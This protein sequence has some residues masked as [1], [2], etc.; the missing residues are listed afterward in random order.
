MASLQG[1]LSYQPNAKA[2]HNRLKAY[3]CRSLGGEHEHEH[4]HEFEHELV[5]CT[6]L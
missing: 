5:Q 1:I 4:E 2:K 6:S 3:R